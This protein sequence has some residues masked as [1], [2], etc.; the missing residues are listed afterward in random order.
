M[1]R[2]VLIGGLVG[3]SAFMFAG[4]SSD[5]TGGY[6][7]ATA[8]QTAGDKGA[9]YLT[10]SLIPQNVDRHGR[11]TTGASNVQVLDQKV[12]QGSGQD[13]V[14]DLLRQQGITH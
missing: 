4:C 1:K 6:R 11:I 3:M 2:A 7:Q 12:I 9:T 5:G 10:G 14:G 13:N 8:T